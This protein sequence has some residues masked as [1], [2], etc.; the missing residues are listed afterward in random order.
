MNIPEIMDREKISVLIE[1]TSG[2]IMGPGLFTMLDDIQY[3][4]GN[5]A[6][7]IIT[8]FLDTLPIWEYQAKLLGI[9]T[10]VIKKAEVIKVG[11]KIST[12]NVVYKIPISSYPVY[13]TLYEEALSKLL[14]SAKSHTGFF[15]NIQIG[16]EGLMSIFDRKELLEQIHDIGEYMVTK[17]KD[18]RDIVFVNVDSLKDTSPYM[19]AMLRSLFPIVLKIMNDG[20][21][22]VVSKSVFPNLKGAVG[23]IWGGEVNEIQKKANPFN[24]HSTGLGSY[25]SH[26]Y[27]E[28]SYIRPI[29]KPR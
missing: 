19:L 27:S 15:I 8:D 1:Y 5:N 28:H 10:E 17:D 21:S 7:V 2:D 22:F 14:E 4:Y 26:N 13:K 11:G 12:G 3:R 20:K 18:V 16:I 24:I 6:F 25:N 23:T 29:R 9:T